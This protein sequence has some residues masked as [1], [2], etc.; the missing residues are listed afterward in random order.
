MNPKIPGMVYMR[1]LWELEPSTVHVSEVCQPNFLSVKGVSNI[2]VCKGVTFLVLVVGLGTVAL[3]GERAVEFL[4][5]TMHLEI[6]EGL[7]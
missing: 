2:Y 1:S 4:A 7:L 3:R 6:L 5:K